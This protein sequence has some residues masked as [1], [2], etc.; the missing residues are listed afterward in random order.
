VVFKINVLYSKV[1][2]NG[3]VAKVTQSLR[4]SQADGCGSKNWVLQAFS[5][6]RMLHT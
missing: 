1:C 5:Q 6:S 4:Q 2:G 3:A